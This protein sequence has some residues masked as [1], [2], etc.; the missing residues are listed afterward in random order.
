MRRR[1]LISWIAV[2]NDPFERDRAGNTFRLVEGSLVP[3]PTLTLLFDADSPYVGSIAD[4][5]LFHSRPPDE[6]ETRQSRAFQQTVQELRLRDPGL[7]IHSEPWDG[8]DPTDHVQLFDFLREKLPAIRRNFADRD[9][10]LHVSPGTPSM[11]TVL[12][13]M[14]ETGFIDP[15]FVLVKSYRKEER[16]GRAAVV[17][18]QLG[19]DSY[20]KGSPRF[21]CNK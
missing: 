13:L 14:G 15:P 5:V 12:V 19:I 21:Q 6:H 11:Q 20:Y 8:D 4:V 10:I 16:N 2:N 7:R 3:G 1:V 17:P 18:V 9:L